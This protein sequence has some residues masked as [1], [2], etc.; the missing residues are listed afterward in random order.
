VRTLSVAQGIAWRTIHNVFTNPA[1]F[2]PSLLFPLFFFTAFAGG[3][4]GIART[5]GFD[6]PS[7]YT[8]FQ[9]VFVLLQSAA[10][11]PASASRATSRAASPGG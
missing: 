9:F 8:A 11:S 10:S 5:P 6:Y 7:G 1:L 3:L 4:S 2:V